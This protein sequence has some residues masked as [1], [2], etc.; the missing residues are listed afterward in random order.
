MYRIPRSRPVSTP[1]EAG[2]H[3]VAYV[4]GPRLAEPFCCWKYISREVRGCL[5]RR[6]KYDMH[7]RL[8]LTYLEV[9]SLVLVEEAEASPLYDESHHLQCGLVTPRV[10]LET[11]KTSDAIRQQLVSAVMADWPHCCFLEGLRRQSEL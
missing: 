4:K 1:Q 6:C 11:R 7:A 8:R 2:L 5:A 9:S 10:Y 3:Q